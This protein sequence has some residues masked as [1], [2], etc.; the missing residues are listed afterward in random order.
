MTGEGEIKASKKEKIEKRNSKRE[1][2]PNSFEVKENL[3][4]PAR[5]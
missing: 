2:R 3:D 5:W 1:E 4:I